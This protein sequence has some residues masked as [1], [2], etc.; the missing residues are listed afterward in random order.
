MD[1]NFIFVNLMTIILTSSRVALWNGLQALAFPMETFSWSIASMDYLV[2][3]RSETKSGRNW[4][5]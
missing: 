1:P 5:S 4:W 2:L 3:F